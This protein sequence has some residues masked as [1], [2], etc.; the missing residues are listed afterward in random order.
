MEFGKTKGHVSPIYICTKSTLLIKLEKE[1]KS[2]KT[3]GHVPVRRIYIKSTL[4]IYELD[5]LDSMNPIIEGTDCHIH[6]NQ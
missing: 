2:G 1:K 6:N 5:G 4:P 3:K